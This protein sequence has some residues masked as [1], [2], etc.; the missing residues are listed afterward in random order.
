MHKPSEGQWKLKQEEGE[1]LF[2]RIIVEAYKIFPIILQWRKQIIWMLSSVF[3]FR[4][5]REGNSGNVLVRWV[6]GLYLSVWESLRRNHKLQYTGSQGDWR[7]NRLR[8]EN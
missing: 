6:D 2:N 1:I 7:A 8:L 5:E 4:G 3:L